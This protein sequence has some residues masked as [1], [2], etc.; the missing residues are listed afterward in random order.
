MNLANVIYPYD[1]GDSPTLTRDP[2][3]RSWSFHLKEINMEAID[4]QKIR[5][6]VFNLIEELREVERILDSR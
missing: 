4:K 2:S 1:F 3:A 6:H 5:N